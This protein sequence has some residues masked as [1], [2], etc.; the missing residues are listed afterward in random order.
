MHMKEED[1]LLKKI[2]KESSF[3]VSDGYFE[4]L[5]SEVMDKL[6][7]KEKVVFE[8]QH[9]TTWTRIKPLLY[10]AAMFIGAALIIRAVS[11]NHTSDVADGTTKK[12]AVVDIG[13]EQVSDELLDATLN[14]AMLDDY[15]LYVYLSDA[16]I[17]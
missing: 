10:M 14:G 15:S 3:K 1:K 6:P 17:E 12:I 5:T 4:K 13:N 7:E 9:V 2:G 8:E 11:F 16:T